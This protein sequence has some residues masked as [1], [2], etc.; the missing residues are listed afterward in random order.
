[1]RHKSGRRTQQAIAIL[2]FIYSQHS[3]QVRCCADLWHRLE[4]FMTHLV[5]NG[6][7]WLIESTFKKKSIH[8]QFPSFACS[9]VLTHIDE[10][11]SAGDAEWNLTVEIISGKQAMLLRKSK[12]LFHFI[13]LSLRHSCFTLGCITD[14]YIFP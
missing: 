10:A 12:Q 5:W 4:A 11:S 14:S 9:S 2:K 13:A 3:R 7:K 6:F 8:G 1:M